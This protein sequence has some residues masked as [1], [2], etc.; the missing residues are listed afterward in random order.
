MKLF[1]YF[2]WGVLIARL[3]YGYKKPI[4]GTEA[5]L[6]ALYVVVTFVLIFMSMA[7][8]VARTPF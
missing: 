3:I 7:L 1:I 6:M 2:I 5:I 8:I 4:T